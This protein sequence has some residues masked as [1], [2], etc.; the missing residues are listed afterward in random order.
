MRLYC[1]SQLLVS[2]CFTLI[3]TKGSR[4]VDLHKTKIY[5]QRKTKAIRRNLG[6]EH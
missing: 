6:L 2:H 4:R 1:N 5:A 3:F